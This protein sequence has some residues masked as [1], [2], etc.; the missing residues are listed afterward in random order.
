MLLIVSTAF[1]KTP[2]LLD[3]ARELSLAVSVFPDAAR[4]GALME[5][6]SRR[7]VLL[8]EQ[9]IE[10]DVLNC[11]EKVEDQAKFGLIICANRDALRSSERSAY[12]ERF[13]RLENVEWL[14][15]KHDIDSLTEAARNCLRRMLRL[16][17]PELQSA[18]AEGQFFLQYQPKVEKR[19]V[20]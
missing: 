13:A 3:A 12:L 14:S 10:I 7:L 18:I 17:K 5:S 6:Q 11:L 15:I 1:G 9:N 16:E 19:S 4:L 20:T 8:H 2:T